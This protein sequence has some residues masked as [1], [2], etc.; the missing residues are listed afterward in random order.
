[1]S[2]RVCI[3][4]AL[5]SILVPAEALFGQA[6]VTR[7]AAVLYIPNEWTFG[8]DEIVAVFRE[9]RNPRFTV[10]IRHERVDPVRIENAKTILALFEARRSGLGDSLSSRRRVAG[11]QVVLKVPRI[12]P[13]HTGRGVSRTSRDAAAALGRANVARVDNLGVVRAITVP[14]PVIK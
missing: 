11:Q 13:S 10:A 5:L 7:H 4:A 12:R 9:H 6:R 8:E 2:L 3:F 1:M 14:L